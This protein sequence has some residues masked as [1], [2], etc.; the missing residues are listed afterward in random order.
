[1]V[2]MRCGG[3]MTLEESYR[4]LG[5]L[6]GASGDERFGVYRELRDKLES[7]RE[8]APT[9]GLGLKYKEALKRIDQAI[10]IVESSIDAMELPVF[11]EGTAT[12]ASASAES[13]SEVLPEPLVVAEKT[14][15]TPVLTPASKRIYFVAGGGLL[16][17]LLLAGTWFWRSAMIE[18]ERVHAEAVAA[19]AVEAERL[20]AEVQRA[21]AM[22]DEELRAEL[23]SK[24]SPIEKGLATIESQVRLAEE[25]LRDLEGVDRVAKTHGNDDESAVSGFRLEHYRSYVEWLRS[26]WQEMPVKAQLAM[27]LASESSEDLEEAVAAI[28][29]ASLDVSKIES[30]ISKA[31][32]ERYAEPVDRFVVERRFAQAVTSSE[33]AV[34]Q[35][36][37]RQAVD[38]IEPFSKSPIVGDDAKAKL[39]RIYRSKSEDAFARAQD[40]ADLGEF[41]LARTILE[42]L[43]D[44]SEIARKSESQL[45]L[46][47]TLNSEYALEQTVAAAERALDE[48]DFERARELL[49][50]LADDPHVGDR[51]AE[52]LA[53]IGEIEEIWKVNTIALRTSNE[54]MPAPRPS[55]TVVPDK[56]PKLIRKVNPIYPDLLRRNKVKGFVDLEWTV[57]VDG[58][59][60]D[61]RII[62]SSRKEFEVPSIE[63]LRK[64]KFR[65]A[66]KEGVPVKMKVRQRI[67]FN[68]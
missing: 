35:H 53:R 64:W 3:I 48:D 1:V 15:A 21:E 38:L 24:R 5:L 31:E 43:D 37:F 8:N 28:G 57:G 54:S 30:E 32:R 9:P 20:A 47:E 11:A 13:E 25:T 17:V 58:K 50:Y 26:Y 14:P 16:F 61:I 49:G 12:S 29:D 40:A 67:L 22:R 23:E 46:V 33:L 52:D 6:E 55:A 39:S 44:D 62:D 4:I 60:I 45:K 18:R 41:E 10:E 65:P 66:E 63:A 59:A 42:T 7:K 19:Q 68:P 2:R 56:T 34:V 27:A 36:D 51:V